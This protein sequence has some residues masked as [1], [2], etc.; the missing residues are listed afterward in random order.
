MPSGSLPTYKYVPPSRPGVAAQMRTCSSRRSRLWAGGTYFRVR[1]PGLPGNLCTVEVFAYSADEAYCRITNTGILYSENVTGAECSVDLLEFDTKVSGEFQDLYE[2]YDLNTLTPHA[3]KYS[4]SLRISF[5]R[6]EGQP[7]TLPTPTELGEFT[8]GK[9]FVS[10]KLS[11]QLTK[12][13]SQYASGDRIFIA[14]RTRLYSL[15]A[16]TVTPPADPVTGV[17][18]AAQTGYDISDLRTK[19][20]T[21]NIWVEVKERTPLP[22]SSGDGL[23]VLM[24]TTYID[25]Q[26]KLQDDLVLTAFEVKNL[27]NGDGL[28]ANPNTEK[29]GPSR[30][31]VH[32]NYGELENGSLGEHNTVYEWVGDSATAGSWKKY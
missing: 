31:I 25:A 3:R 4:I 29:T 24:P 22:A 1:E 12:K 18:G 26:D 13:S 5:A 28:P 17:A 7:Y 32:V 21:S 27:A 8:F 2:L 16:L 19:V 10:G 6:Q 9:L 23:P 14:P 30:S 15:S 20:N 11:V